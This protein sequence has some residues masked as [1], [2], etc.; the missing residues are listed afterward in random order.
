M[1]TRKRINITMHPI[2][3]KKLDHIA[4]QYQETRSG[5]IERLIQGFKEYRDDK[6]IGELTE[7]SYYAP[8]KKDKDKVK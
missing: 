1:A 5:M 4:K 7:M 6:D 2:E 3:L 8:D